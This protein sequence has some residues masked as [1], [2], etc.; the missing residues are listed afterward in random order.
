MAP[1]QL[2][3]LLLLCVSVCVTAHGGVW[4]CGAGTR[5]D[6]LC[7][8]YANPFII[9]QTRRPVLLLRLLLL[10]LRVPNTASLSLPCC[11]PLLV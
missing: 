1:L 7:S 8:H 10:P 3:L 9:R 6:L 11:V 5:A 2:S 4:E